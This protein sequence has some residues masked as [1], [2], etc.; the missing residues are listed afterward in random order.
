[1]LVH[2]VAG[3]WVELVSVRMAAEQVWVVQRERGWV[4]GEDKI[5]G[6]QDHNIRG[7]QGL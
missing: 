2:G 5:L 7:V 3:C 1:V 6:V 4:Q